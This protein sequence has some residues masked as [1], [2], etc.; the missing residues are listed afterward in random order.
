MAPSKAFAHALVA[1]FL[2][3]FLILTAFSTRHLDY[4]DWRFLPSWSHF[5]VLGP[6]LALAFALFR[7]LDTKWYVVYAAILGFIAWMMLR[8]EARSIAR[9]AGQNLVDVCFAVLTTGAIAIG[10]WSRK[11]HGL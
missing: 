4:F 8:D 3:A 7:V 11:R 6:V 1:T 9:V 10:V 5:L 2:T